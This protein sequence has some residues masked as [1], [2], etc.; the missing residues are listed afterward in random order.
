MLAASV[1]LWERSYRVEDGIGYA[2][3][4]SKSSF[5]NFCAFSKLGLVY[6]ERVD[7]PHSDDP[8]QGIYWYAFD[9]PLFIL[10]SGPGAFEGVHYVS[11]PTETWCA[12]VPHWFVALVAS[13]LPARWLML[14][15][16]RRRERGRGFEVSVA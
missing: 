8:G 13:L 15:W 5:A 1:A 4:G 16:G 2:R 14:A 7:W 10:N 11:Y 12:A 3:H 9:G 6:V